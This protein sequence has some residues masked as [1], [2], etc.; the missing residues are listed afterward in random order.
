MFVFAVVR[1]HDR[2]AESPDLARRAV[3]LATEMRMSKKIDYRA[4]RGRDQ[5]VIRALA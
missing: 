2:L 4:A 5:N 3:P 1:D